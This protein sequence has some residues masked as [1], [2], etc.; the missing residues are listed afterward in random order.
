MNGFARRLVLKQRQRVTRKWPICFFFSLT[1][2]KGNL[3][4][5]LFF[6]A[7]LQLDKLHTSPEEVRT[8]CGLPV[9]LRCTF[10][11][12]AHPVRAVITHEGKTVANQE[13]GTQT[14]TTTAGRLSKEYGLYTC[15]AEDANHEKI[16][17]NIMLR[18]IGTPACMWCNYLS[19]LVYCRLQ[20]N[21]WSQEEGSE[22]NS[23]FIPIFGSRNQLLGCCYVFSLFSTPR[24]IRWRHTGKR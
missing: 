23:K 18:Q 24:E 17:Y 6:P 1:I 16:T 5:L 20:G 12:G 9:E 7:P 11:Y 3:F 13:N 10:K 21:V 15:L 14:V 2:F 19:L 4:D 22:W 8:Y